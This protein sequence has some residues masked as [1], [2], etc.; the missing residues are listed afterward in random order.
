[1]KLIRLVSDANDGF[2][3][4]D[5]K[6]DLEIPQN[7]ELALQNLSIELESSE[8]E[9]NTTNDIITFG[10][11]AI[12][13]I[14]TLTNK[15]YTYLS[16]QDLLDDIK[17]S[18]NK[19]LSINNREDIGRLW[20][21]EISKSKVNISYQQVKYYPPNPLLG[22]NYIISKNVNWALT[23][24]GRTGD[25]DNLTIDSFLAQTIPAPKTCSSINFQLNNIATFTP[26]KDSEL[27]VG[28]MAEK[29]LADGSNISTSNIFFG[30]TLSK[31]QT[32]N[33][34]N[35]VETEY[36]DSSGNS[37]APKI[38]GPGRTTNDF[39]QIAISNGK[40]QSILYTD[41]ALS[42]I[43]TNEVGYNY[44]TE[45][46]PIIMFGVI[47]FNIIH[48]AINSIRNLGFM[49]DPQYVTVSESIENNND[50]E[51]GALP[52]NPAPI[53]TELTNNYFVMS[54][55]VAEFLDFVNV[56]S[57]STL[58]SV[59]QSLSFLGTLTLVQNIPDSIII[60]ML[61][62]ELNSYDSLFGGRKNILAVIPNVENISNRLIYS[63]NFPLF[64]EINNK[65]PR[66][67]RNIKARLLNTDYSTL[68]LNG[69][70]VITLILK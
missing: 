37:V 18:L 15:K 28:Y 31:T 13:H 19:V 68:T 60:E 20:N 4:I 26:A 34:V 35:G 57:P 63:A 59:N 12:N 16:R 7:A 43:I 32:F 14:A 11:N 55:S 65:Q 6:E 69:Q 58:N 42:P 22:L 51:L 33:I 41:G 49:A 70:N 54:D 27:I 50:D 53:T 47:G 1:M 62:V 67:L 3:D 29:P 38:I 52:P 44:T 36:L 5:F 61:N 56:P 40:L 8:V 48:K 2:F 25:G 64:I 17:T 10:Y 39:W 46:Y 24:V 23:V 21:V 9:V 45:L 30:I 66:L